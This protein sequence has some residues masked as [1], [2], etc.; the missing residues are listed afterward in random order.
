LKFFVEIPAS[1]SGEFGDSQ[2]WKTSSDLENLLDII[3]GWGI[4][5]VCDALRAAICRTL[6]DGFSQGDWQV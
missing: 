2:I 1:D 3:I 4:G 5:S 6:V